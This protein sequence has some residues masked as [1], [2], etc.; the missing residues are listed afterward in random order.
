[1]DELRSYGEKTKQINTEI[2]KK[3]LT[4]TGLLQIG[5]L[6]SSAIELDKILEFSVEKIMHLPDI[7]GCF[8]MMLDEDEKK[9][10]VKSLSGL[11]E[12]QLTLKKIRPG[13]GLVGKIA[14]QNKPFILDADTK[15]TTEIEDFRNEFQL[16]NCALFPV[17]SAGK[18]TGV[19][20]VGNTIENYKF[21]QDDLELFE[22]FVKQMGIAVENDILIKKAEEL[23]ITDELT[24]LYNESY[25]NARLD[26]E[27]K[28]AIIY[29]RPCAFIILDVDDFKVFRDA[30]GEIAAEE[31]L[32]KI[33][34]ILKESAT[35]ID[36]VSRFSDDGFAIVLP[37]KNKRDTAR[38]AE[39]LRIK[40]EEASIG[41]KKAASHGLTVSAGISENPIDGASAQEL[42][43][44][45]QACLKKAKDE[46]KNKVAS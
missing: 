32:R 15:T 23:E 24:G 44:K 38:T 3:V 37:E 41:K 16:T 12:T 43:D 1:M 40:I 39:E 2:H 42:V 20:G 14:K 31:A 46:G 19:L 7:T 28:R 8:L 13:E 33:S 27:I 45:A 18:T 34:S 6:I 25:I 11:E 35:P 36:K 29:Q 4:M 9:L 21:T 30:Q 22:V 26:E 10:A 17:V 5:N